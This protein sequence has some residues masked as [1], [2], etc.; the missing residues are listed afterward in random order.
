MSKKN[1][2]SPGFIRIYSN[3]YRAF[4]ALAAEK[5][6]VRKMA[7]DLAQ[8]LLSTR[9][10]LAQNVDIINT[11]GAKVGEPLPQTRPTPLKELSRPI[12]EG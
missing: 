1:Q 2:G 9:R 11:H 4:P 5:V 7:E 10:L 6:D 12:W 3:H 8:F